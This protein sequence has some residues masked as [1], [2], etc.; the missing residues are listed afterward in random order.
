MREHRL[1]ARGTDACQMAA[2]SALGEALGKEFR[3]ALADLLLEMHAD[4]LLV[5]PAKDLTSPL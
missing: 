2:T 1:P 4:L 5:K 3:A